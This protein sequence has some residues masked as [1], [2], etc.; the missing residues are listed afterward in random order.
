[1]PPVECYPKAK[2]AATK[3][4]EIEDSLAE[5]HTSL[6]FAYLLYDWDFAQAE[7][8]FKRAIKLNPSYAN[9][10][11]GYGFYLKATG[12]NEA[13]IRESQ[14]AQKLEPLS[15]FATVSLGWA[16]YFARQYD[17]AVEQGRKALEMDPR[18][19]FAHRI[20]GVALTQQGKAQEAVASMNQAVILTGGAITYMAYL[21]YAYGMA[22]MRAEARLMIEDLE[23]QAK[24][25]YVP[26]YYFAIIYLGLGE[27]DQVFAWLERAFEERSGFLAYLKVEP[28]LDP[29]R[30]DPRFS[31][32][33]HRIGFV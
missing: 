6:G 24:Q 27:P 18:F 7:R 29:L 2:A 10:H 4:L 16:Y 14:R 33:L 32:L 20:V 15:L 31:S 13:A 12:Q 23:E 26:S 5:A 11:D 28:M 8:E 25:T 3:A 22:D 19:D 17:R 30:D 1:L 9:A 21:G